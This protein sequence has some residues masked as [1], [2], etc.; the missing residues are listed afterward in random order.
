M[1]ELYNTPERLYRLANAR[2]MALVT[3]THPDE[4]NCDLTIADRDDV[5]VGCEITATFPDDGVVCHIGVLGINEEQHRE[6]QKLKNNPIELVRYLK[7]QEIF[8]TL[9]HLASLSAGRLE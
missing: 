5:I 9:N 6:A 8:S 1:N 4:I 3:I 7:Q 2:G